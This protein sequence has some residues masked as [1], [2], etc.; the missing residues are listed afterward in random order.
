MGGWRQAV[1]CKSCGRKPAKPGR[2]GDCY[3]CSVSGIGL[4]FVGGGGRTR[5]MFHDY[6][7]AERRAE[8]L[9]DRVVGKD[10]APASDFGW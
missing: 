4:S 10:V 7:V 8:I 1:M 9:G 5:Q 2:K 3:R 6:T